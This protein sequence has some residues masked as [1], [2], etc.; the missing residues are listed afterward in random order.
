MEFKSK[1]NNYMIKKH[2]EKTPEG[3]FDL[4]LGGMLKGFGELI[5]KLGELAKTGEQMSRTGEIHGSGKEVKG[6]YGVTVKVGLG[7]ARPFTEER[8][9]RSSSARSSH[10]LGLKPRG[11]SVTTSSAMRT[12]RRTADRS[13]RTLPGQP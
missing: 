4:G 13:C 3:G 11:S 10:A 9:T 2:N 5:D 1:E 12:A 8:T 6:I 7:D